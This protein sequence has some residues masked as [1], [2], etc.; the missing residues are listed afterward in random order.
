MTRASPIL[1]L[2]LGFLFLAPPVTAQ[3]VP[4]G[5]PEAIAAF[6]EGMR[7][8]VDGEH[9]DA[10]TY[11]LKAHELD[12]TFAV[13]LFMAS[14][15]EGN[16]G[17]AAEA[18]KLREEAWKHRDRLS[19]YYQHRLDAQMAMHHED[20]LRASRAAAELGPG[21]KAWYNLALYSDY[22]GR[23]DEGLEALNKLNPDVEPM[24]DWYSYWSVKSDLLHE[25]GH[26]EEALG[27][28]R[29]GE[30]RFPDAQVY[31][32]RQ[33]ELL[34]AMGRA[35][36]LDDL[37]AA[38]ALIEPVGEAYTVGALTALASAEALAHGHSDLAAELAPEAVDW[39]RDT[40]LHEGSAAHRNW[41]GYSLYAAGDF[42]AS[43]DV[44]EGLLEEAPTTA[45]FHTA[46]GLVAIKQG[47]R[48]RFEA[49]RDWVTRGHA[50]MT[51]AMRAQ[52]LAYLAGGD[53]DAEEAV[54]QLQTAVSLGMAYQNWWHRHSAFEN[55][56]D[57]PVFKAFFEPGT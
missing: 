9:A 4:E 48:A 2:V 6:A 42:D 37:L 40:G 47:D 30:K 29:E 23:F 46:A 36:E 57:D 41:Y 15:A 14:L 3:D 45:W 44:Y 52:L 54:R 21:T 33:A 1:F 25:T 13:A 32:L 10:A 53:G 31:L 39:Y 35:A 43:R 56:W 20:R 19:P 16:A 38:C 26:F 8:Y 51:P 7:L 17:N 49:E 34:G 24:K 22:A 50:D 5:S 55:I 18:R 11:F 12:N 28:A 27:A